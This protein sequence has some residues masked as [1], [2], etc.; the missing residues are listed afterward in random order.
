VGDEMTI[1]L[2]RET[3]R[4]EMCRSVEDVNNDDEFKESEKRNELLLAE[5]ETL[6]HSSGNDSCLVGNKDCCEETKRDA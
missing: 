2:A 5:A 6:T 3:R 4:V 1:V